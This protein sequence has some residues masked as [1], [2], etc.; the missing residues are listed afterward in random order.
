LKVCNF[1]I[2]LDLNGDSK[3]DIVSAQGA[4]RSPSSSIKRTTQHQRH[5]QRYQQRSTFDTTLVLSGGT[6]VIITTD[7][8]GAF[9]FNDLTA[10]QTYTLTPPSK[11]YFAPL[12]QTFN[13][14]SSNVVANFTGTLNNYT[15]SDALATSQAM[16]WPR[17]HYSVR[18]DDGTITTGADGTYA[19]TNLPGE[20]TIPSLHHWRN[21]CSLHSLPRYQPVE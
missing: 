1:A 8:T 12:N 11:L 7:A 18:S 15:I 16:E 13:N 20:A 5:R 9:A 21:L 6:P 14:L 10:G 17:D 3:P 2:V 19:F 4:I